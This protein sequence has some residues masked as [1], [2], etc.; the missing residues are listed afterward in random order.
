MIC[1]S[2]IVTCLRRYNVEPQCSV[3]GN[4]GWYRQPPSSGIDYNLSEYYYVHAETSSSR[5]WWQ[6]DF[7]N[8]VYIKQYKLTSPC[9]CNFVKE[10]EFQI[11]FNGNQWETVD[12]QG[13]GFSNNATFTLKKTAVT[14]YVRLLGSAPNC[15]NTKILAFTRIYF[16]HPFS[17]LNLDCNTRKYFFHFHSCLF[18]CIFFFK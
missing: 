14:R 5:N 16:Y 6:V 4:S 3:S 11:S 13:I 17:L 12:K 1:T 8:I 15:Q 2:D 18:I 9:A 7:K 10:W